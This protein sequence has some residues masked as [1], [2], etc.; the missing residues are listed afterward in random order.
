MARATN[1][2]SRTA[3]RSWRSR[4]QFGS[5]DRS[6]MRRGLRLRRMS[7][8]C[9][10]S[11][12]GSVS[13][14]PKRWKRTCSISPIDVRP[15]SRLSCQIKVQRSAGRARRSCSQ[16]PGLIAGRRGHSLFSLSLPCLPKKSLAGQATSEDRRAHRM[17]MRREHLPH[18]RHAR[19]TC[20]PPPSRYALEETKR[21]S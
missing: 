10:R 9:R 7:C 5:R 18:Q 17:Q 11:L 19:R 4:S 20:L 12:G 1:S 3:P 8:L 16:T 15:T 14:R 13:A 6:G 21:R 2:M